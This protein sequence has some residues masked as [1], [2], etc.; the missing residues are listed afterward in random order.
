MEHDSDAKQTECEVCKHQIS[1][2]ARECPHCGHILDEDVDKLR[3][4]ATM[5]SSQYQIT[6]NKF[7][8]TQSRA[9]NVLMFISINVAVIVVLLSTTLNFADHLFPGELITVVVISMADI[10]ITG[11]LGLKVYKIMQTR[12]FL[13]ITEPKDLN[14]KLFELSSKKA[15]G[16]IAGIYAEAEKHLREYHEEKLRIYINGLKLMPGAYILSTLLI[17]VV[18]WMIAIQTSLVSSDIARDSWTAFFSIGLSITFL[19]SLCSL[20]VAIASLKRTG[21]MS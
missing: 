2:H 7:L 13:G 19:C 12:T 20:A 3:H 14:K 18:V 1:K 5:A 11:I 9:G 15:L 16:K 6:W 21:G 17:I 10:L 8:A 4:I